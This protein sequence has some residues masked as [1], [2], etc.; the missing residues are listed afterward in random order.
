MDRSSFLV[1]SILYYINRKKTVAYIS[2][3]KINEKYK[4]LELYD[5]LEASSHGEINKM[6][7]PLFKQY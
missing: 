1:N 6:E 2:Q 5:F 7:D 3:S 4:S